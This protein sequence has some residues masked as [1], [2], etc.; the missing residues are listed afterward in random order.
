MKYSS[1]LTL[2]SII[3]LKGEYISIDQLMPEFGGSR[4][5]EFSVSDYFAEDP[6]LMYSIEGTQIVRGIPSIKDFQSDSIQ[7]EIDQQQQQQQ[8]QQTRR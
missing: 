4:S 3:I 2:N 7:S 5:F 8:Q 1:S 6:T